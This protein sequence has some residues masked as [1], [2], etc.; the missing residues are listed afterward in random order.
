[1]IPV[2]EPTERKTERRKVRKGTRS[3]WECKRRKIRCIFASTDD[4]VCVSCQR[5]RAPC[6]SQEMPEDL[7]PAKRGNRHLGD[8]ISRVEDLVKDF[9]TAKTSPDAATT[10]SEIPAPASVRPPLTPV[11][12]CVSTEFVILPKIDLSDMCLESMSWRHGSRVAQLKKHTWI[13]NR[14]V[15]E[16]SNNPSPFV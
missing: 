4:A 12:V 9:L 1:M 10:R 5:R 15:R 3:C 11:E 13:S 6:V 2:E 8:R 16:R 14:P 7:A